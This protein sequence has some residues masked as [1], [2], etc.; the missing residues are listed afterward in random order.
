MKFERSQMGVIMYRLKVQME[1]SP[2]VNYF[3]IPCFK[4][5][6]L[7]KSLSF[8]MILSHFVLANASSLK[9]LDACLNKIFYIDTLIHAPYATYL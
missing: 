6:I 2:V 5:L 3:P 8:I 9:M 1:Y 4:R 7:G